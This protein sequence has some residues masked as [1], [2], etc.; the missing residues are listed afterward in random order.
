MKKTVKAVLLAIVFLLTATIQSF[1]PT[2]AASRP[3][4]KMLASLTL[5]CPFDNMKVHIFHVADLSDDGFLITQGAFQY[6]GFAITNN[7]SWTDLAET[8]AL[9]VKRDKIPPT[10]SEYS[11]HNG[12]A[13]FDKLQCGLYLIT[14]DP[15][16]I[17]TEIIITQP[18]MVSLPTLDESSQEWMYDVVASPKNIT[19]STLTEV[20]IEVIKVWDDKGAE[21]NRPLEIEAELLRNGEVFETVVLNEENN[22]R[23]AWS[24]LDG[25]YDW[26]VLEKEIPY[27]YTVLIMTEGETVIITNKVPESTPSETPTSP[28]SDTPSTEPTSPP[29]NLP[30]T[31]QLWWPVGVLAVCGLIMVFLGLIK[32]RYDGK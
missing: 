27:G 17:E 32:R 21:I 4:P 23:Y 7:G 31:G 11:D 10:R 13:R 20:S 15:T 14:V 8:L 22:W 24:G 9:Y 18:I 3:D 19:R 28:G 25:A 12:V 29:S 26:S 1:N 5:L 30:Q 6:R 2:H 16:V